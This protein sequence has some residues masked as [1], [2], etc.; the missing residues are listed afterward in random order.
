M[1]AG[2]SRTVWSDMRRHGN[3]SRRTLEKLLAV[4]GSSLAEFEAL[5]IGPHAIGPGTSHAALGDVGRPW[6]HAPLPS[7]PLFSSRVGGTWD[8]PEGRVDLT[9]IVREPRSELLPRPSSLALDHEAFALTIVTNSMWPRFSEGRR[10]AVSPQS[11][12][13]PGDDVVVKPRALSGSTTGEFD[14]V[15]IMHLT[16]RTRSGLRLRQFQP[17]FTISIRLE[18]VAAIMRVAGELF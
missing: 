8:A 15:L 18:H 2:V 1:R 6:G 10:V 11:K 17:D 4:A 16:D 14:S 9:E 7:L 13:A 3:P 12:V 5:R